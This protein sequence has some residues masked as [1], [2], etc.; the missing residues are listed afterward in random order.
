MNV[1]APLP[2]LSAN[3]AADG[4][5]DA[6]ASVD[7]QAG[8]ETV[9]R[10]ALLCQIDEVVAT[11]AAGFV[12][13]FYAVFAMQEALEFVEAVMCQ[14]HGDEVAWALALAQGKAADDARCLHLPHPLGAGLRAEMR[15]CA[16]LLPTD[17]AVLAQ[18][19]K[20][21]LTDFVGKFFH[22]VVYL[23]RKR[24]IVSVRKGG[25]CIP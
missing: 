1:N 24:R 9:Q 21:V 7:T 15:G 25:C 3:N 16:E 4:A 13:A 2:L 17:A 22:A 10:V 5:G 12:R 23:R 14:Q 18:R 8:Q 11:V 6:V 20:D 19:G